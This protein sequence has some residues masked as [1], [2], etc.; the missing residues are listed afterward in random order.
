MTGSGGARGSRLGRELSS[1]FVCV[2]FWACG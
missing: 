2:E 1:A